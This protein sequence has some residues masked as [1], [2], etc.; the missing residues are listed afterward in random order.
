MIRERAFAKVKLVLQVGHPR[1]DG[2]HPICSLFASIDLADDVEVEPAGRDEV[3]CP[4][5]AGA[6][7]CQEA[8]EAFRRAAELPPVRVGVE[9]RIPVA[10]GLGGGSADAAAVLRAANELAGRPLTAD[11][12][13]GVAAG[14]GSDVPSQVEPRH[15]LVGGYG[16]IVEPIDLPPAAMV[17]VPAAEGLL[18]G[19]VY[20]EL[21]RIGGTRDSLDPG[22]LRALAAAPLGELAAGLQ[23]DLQPAA[24]SLRPEL[25]GA[26][27]TLRERGA[28]AAALSGSGPTA[29]GLF[30]D[31]EAAERAAAGIPGALVART[32]DGA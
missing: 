3:A 32:R 29:L 18:T 19:D 15:A 21:D 30:A 10:A 26:L 5:V 31:A 6:N 8:L 20:V 11:D 17:L 4:G 1:A 16:E 27:A 23:N 7:L 12:L 9:K 2:M 22:R 24:L 13:R 28:L 25:D 14:L